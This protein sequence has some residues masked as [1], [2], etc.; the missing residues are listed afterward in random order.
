M[1]KYVDCHN[2]QNQYDCE[3]TYLGGCTNGQ[4]WAQREE[5]KLTDEEV[6]EALKYCVKG[7]TCTACP[8]FIKQIDCVYH[9][10]TEGDALDLI[11]RQKAEIE[12]LKLDLKNEKNW[13]KIQT[14]QTVKDTAKEI[15]QELEDKGYFEYGQFTI[16]GNDFIEIFKKRGVEVE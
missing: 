13:G 4:E 15:Y 14:K 11:H 7:E 8:Y 16:S 5:R 12:R 2:C 1:E 6:I 10:R 9:R 3:K